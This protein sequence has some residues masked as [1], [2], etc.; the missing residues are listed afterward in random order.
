LPFRH[1]TSFKTLSW[2]GRVAQVV[3]RL[4]SKHEALN[5]NP[6][7]GKKKKKRGKR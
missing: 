2:A 4:T 3:E 5:S 7:T 6:R 1:K